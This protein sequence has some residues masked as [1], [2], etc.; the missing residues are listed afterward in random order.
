[1]D[2][3]ESK[4]FD[5]LYGGIEE[6]FCSNKKLFEKIKQLE[7]KIIENEDKISILDDRIERLERHFW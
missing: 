2:E 3:R 4:S 5:E 6:N 1:M 7:K